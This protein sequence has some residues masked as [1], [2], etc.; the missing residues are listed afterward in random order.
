MDNY[1]YFE[2]SFSALSVNLVYLRLVVSAIC[3][4]SRLKNYGGNESLTKILF[5]FIFSSVIFFL[6]GLI[7]LKNYDN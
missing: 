2:L 6:Q 3:S 5:F 1:E 7:D 4:F